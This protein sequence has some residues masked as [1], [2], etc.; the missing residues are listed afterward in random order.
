[1]AKYSF[2]GHFHYYF[3]QVV[4]LCLFYLWCFQWRFCLCLFRCFLC[5]FFPT[6][7]SRFLTAFRTFLPCATC[8]CCFLNTIC[9]CRA[10]FTR[11]CFRW[12]LRQKALI[13]KELHKPMVAKRCQLILFMSSFFLCTI[14]AKPMKAMLRM[15]RFA[16]PLFP[17]TGARVVIACAEPPLSEFLVGSNFCHFDSCYS[18]FYVLIY[19]S[20]VYVQL[21]IFSIILS[22]RWP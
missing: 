5:Y 22:K 16:C 2:V 18:P 20:L 9:H 1:M 21:L 11:D 13:T 19:C 12:L 3:L 14:P 17:H 8:W 15:L 4:L 10:T 6:R 7:F